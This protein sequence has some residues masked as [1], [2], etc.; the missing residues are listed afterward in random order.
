MLTLIQLTGCSEP[1]VETRT[2]QQITPQQEVQ[3]QV[4]QDSARQWAP[5]CGDGWL[6]EEGSDGDTILWAGLSEHCDTVFSSQGP[7]GRLYRNPGKVGTTDT[8]SF[9]RDMLLG[10]LNCLVS[11]KNTDSAELF[12]SYLR[13]N[14]Y[15]MCPTDTDGRCTLSYVRHRTLWGIM[16]RVWEHMGL[17][18][19]WEMQQAD[20]GDDSLLVQ[21]A[22]YTP[23][24]YA[25]H[26]VSIQAYIRHRLDTATD[27][28]QQAVRYLE[29]RQRENP[30]FAYLR[31]GNEAQV[32]KS[33]LD[34]CPTEKPARAHQWAWQRDVEEKAWESSMGWDCIFLSQLLLDAAAK[35]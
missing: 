7:D 34:K 32:A 14:D 23:P 6:C 29:Q 15:K 18:P 30:W 27:K 26:L 20:Y 8:N 22:K 5:T 28:T 11:M 21:S 10:Y 17:E 16:L 24:G 13:D 25:L 33:L 2:R 19:S 9:S 35:D 4:L 31:Y 1:E 12:L 3:L